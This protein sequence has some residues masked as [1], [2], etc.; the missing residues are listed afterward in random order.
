METLI[1]NY[2]CEWREAVETPEIRS[3]FV[4]FVNAPE[5][6]DPTIA[7]EPLRNQIIA[8]DWN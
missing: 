2:K 1:E 7:F 8:K 4:H 6:K 5:L 3:R